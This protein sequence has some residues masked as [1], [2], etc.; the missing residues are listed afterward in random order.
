MSSRRYLAEVTPEDALEPAQDG[1]SRGGRPIVYGYGLKWLA[2]RA[3]RSLQTV[4]AARKAGV[5]L[6]DPVEAVA[7][8][9][10]RRGHRDLAAQ[11]RAGLGDPTITPV[12]ED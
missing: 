3:G 10:E 9:L 7:W 5:R 2:A 4:R 12:A 11:V 6:H 8:A 1:Q